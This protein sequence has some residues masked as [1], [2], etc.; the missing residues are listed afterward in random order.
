SPQSR[1]QSSKF[2]A[3]LALLKDAGEYYQQQLRQHPQKE[4]AVSYLKSRGLS[5]EIARDFGLGYAPPGW[6][7]VLKQLGGDAP[8]QRLLFEAG[9]L[10]GRTAEKSAENDKR[11]PY[12]DRFRDRI[13]YP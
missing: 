2:D 6:D 1:Q 13:M 4:R 8:K 7:N 11:S 5:G 12:Y 3:M 10:V 9:L